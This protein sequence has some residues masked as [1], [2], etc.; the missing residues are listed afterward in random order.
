MGSGSPGSPSAGAAFV[1][2]ARAPP[3]L[4]FPPIGPKKSPSGLS[5]SPE[6]RKDK[7][8]PKAGGGSGAWG[9]CPHLHFKATGANEDRE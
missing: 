9:N 4:N 6:F 1:E 7:H 2:L 5:S 3:S 8:R